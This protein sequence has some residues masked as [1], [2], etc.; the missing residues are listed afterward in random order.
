MHQVI[1]IL[2]ERTKLHAE[3][4]AAEKAGDHLAVQKLGSQLYH[5]KAESP[6]KAGHEAARSQGGASSCCTSP[7]LSPTSP[8][9]KQRIGLIHRKES[10]CRSIF[11]D[12]AAAEDDSDGEAE[13]I[14]G[15]GD[16]PALERPPTFGGQ[17]GRPTGAALAARGERCDLDSHGGAAPNEMRQLAQLLKAVRFFCDRDITNDCDLVEIAKSLLLETFQRDEMIFD[18]GDEGDKFYIVVAGSVSIRIPILVP[19]P[20]E[21]QA[22]R[23]KEHQQLSANL[24]AL[25]ARLATLADRQERFEKFQRRFGYGDGALGSQDSAGSGSEEGGRASG[26][27]AR[28]SVFDL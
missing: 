9:M 21:E 8:T 5:A 6:R 17:N 27:D 24:T 20:A 4:Q 7:A 1:R 14:D 16:P 19:V 2:G 28:G 10:D 18:Y 11:D 22:S 25:R 3:L 23:K 15:L 13:E 12:D 26:L